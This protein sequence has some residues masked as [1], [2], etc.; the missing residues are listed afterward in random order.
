M[1][2]ALWVEGPLTSRARSSG[3][4]GSKGTPTASIA[5]WRSY[6][7]MSGSMA[8][9]SRSSCRAQVQPLK[10]CHGLESESAKPPLQNGKSK[11]KEQRAEHSGA[12]RRTVWKP[13][14]KG[15]HCT[16]GN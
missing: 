6:R 12:S 14:L 5:S 15:Q 1:Q 3:I 13:Q 4:S 11:V 8:M 9:E 10:Y 2:Q 16:G 7:G